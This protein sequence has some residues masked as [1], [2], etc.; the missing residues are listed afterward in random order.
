MTWR[1]SICGRRSRALN[2]SCA[3][4]TFAEVSLC[5]SW[6]RCTGKRCRLSGWALIH[7]SFRPTRRELDQEDELEVLCVGRLVASKGQLVLLRATEILLSKGYSFRVRLL[8]AGPERK[9]LEDFVAQKNIPVVFDGAKT[10]DETRQLLDR[11][12][13]FALASFAEGVPV[14]LMEAMAMEIPCVSTCIAGIPE[15]IRDGLDGLLVPASSAESLAAALQ[16][17]LDDPLLRRSLG[18]AGSKRVRDYYNL[19]QNVRSLAHIFSEQ[20]SDNI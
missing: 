17:L 18:V 9:Q 11:A 6:T 2:S 14:A 1:N 3:L 16:R 8:G 15:L 10:H 13:I 7:A 19:P 20:L 4:A 12:D 5:A